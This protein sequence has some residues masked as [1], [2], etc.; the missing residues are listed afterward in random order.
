MKY[1]LHLLVFIAMIALNL[2]W[3]DW[4]E[5]YPLTCYLGHIVILTCYYCAIRAINDYY[6]FK[7][8]NNG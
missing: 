8:I 3:H 6:L 5:G 7:G 1:L 2:I 4:N